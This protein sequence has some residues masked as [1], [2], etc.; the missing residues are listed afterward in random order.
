MTTIYS[1]ALQP[2]KKY[3]LQALAADLGLDNTGTKDDVQERIKNHL[4]AHQELSQDERF[5]GLYSRKKTTRGLK[6]SSAQ[7]PDVP[8]VDDT[9]HVMTTR[10][11]SQR[12]FPSPDPKHKRTA[13]PEPEPETEQPVAELPPPPSSPVRSIVAAFNKAV[14]AAPEAEVVKQI[15]EER[16]KQA[17]AEA[18]RA[19]IN[20]KTFLSNAKNI[21]TITIFAELLFAIYTFVPW[22][23]YDI[24]LNA[25]YRTHFDGIIPP[26][27]PNGAPLVSTRIMHVPYPPSWFLQTLW[28]YTTVLLWLIPT[29]ILPQ[30]IGTLVSFRPATHGAVK[31]DGE[32]TEVRQAGG[33]A[34]PLTAAIIRV[35]CVFAGDWGLDWKTIGINKKWRVLGSAVAA[36]FALAE[37]VGERKAALLAAGVIE[38]EAE[39]E[40]EPQERALTLRRRAVKST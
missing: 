37:A 35:A 28:P 7:P 13:V 1:G 8:S 30:L 25:P 32:A 14:A 9:Q 38:E 18:D 10:R 27:A 17:Y 31:G 40:E 34:D 26:G 2:K 29:V 20:A 39:E 16:G 21:S 6:E 11:S 23:Y 33:E 5:V 15:V 19:L 22:A 3:E 4:A 24:P 36:A 12:V